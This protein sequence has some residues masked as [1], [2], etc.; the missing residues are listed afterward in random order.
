[1]GTATERGESTPAGRRRL[2][3]NATELLRQPGTRRRIAVSLPLSELEVVDPRLS[4]DVDVDVE[5]ISTLDDIEVSGSLTARW[6]DQCARCLRPLDAPLVVEVEE[7]YA[8][9]STDPGHPTDP[10][11]FPIEHGQIDLA[12]MAR[13]EVLLGIPDAPICRADCPGLCPICGADLSV[14]PC[15]CDTALRDERWAALDALRDE[16]GPSA[17]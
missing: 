15:G 6:S 5:L 10:E 16:T 11:S 7:R 8:V 14:G 1:M 12:P 13:E 4:G 2:L 9:P 17:N 3:V